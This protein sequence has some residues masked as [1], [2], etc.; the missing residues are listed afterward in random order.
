MNK[1]T[2][3]VAIDFDGTI[4]KYSPY[5]IMGDVREQIPTFLKALHNRGYRMVLNTCR[6]GEYYDEAVQC[7][8][9]NNLYDLF[10]WEY[11]E[12]ESNK[13]RN[14][15]LV[16]TFY[17]DDSALPFDD[18]DYVSWSTLTECVIEKIEKKMSNG[19]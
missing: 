3:T 14:G 13:G 5:P 15:K 10:D 7:L 8:K 12:K 1:R 16:A 2:A 19:L 17:F 9:D 11:A 6:V 18:L 4:T